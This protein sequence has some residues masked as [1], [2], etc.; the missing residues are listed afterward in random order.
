MELCERYSSKVMNERANGTILVDVAPKDVKQ[1]EVMRP[2]SAPS[3]GQR[4]K[5]SLEKE[6]RLE[7][8]SKPIQSKSKNNAN[9]KNSKDEGSE[10]KAAKTSK[11]KKKNKKQKREKSEVD[12][13]LEKGNTSV[14]QA[15]EV[16]EGINW[17]DEE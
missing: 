12:E 9:A 16:E 1:L 5:Q 13:A 3:M 14:D 11:K 15:D 8:A 2:H 17:S 7:A 10:E 6:K 4:F